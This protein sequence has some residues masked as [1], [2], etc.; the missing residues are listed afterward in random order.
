MQVMIY[1]GI[2]VK[3][4]WRIDKMTSQALEQ[5]LVNELV[6]RMGQTKT[7]VTID[8][9]TNGVTQMYTGP[10]KPLTPF[11]PTST[12]FGINLPKIDGIKDYH[13]T[14]KIDRYDNLYGGHSSITPF[15]GNKFRINHND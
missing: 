5:M 10:M 2:I 14:F 3:K 11:F 12:G 6:P 13:E 9:Y 8:V 4:R 15:G 7:Y 1:T